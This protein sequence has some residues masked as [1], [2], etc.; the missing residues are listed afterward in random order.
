MLVNQIRSQSC[1]VWWQPQ[2]MMF[3]GSESCLNQTL[4][5]RSTTRNT[6]AH[7]H[8]YKHLHICIHTNTHAH[9]HENTHTHMRAL[10]YTCTHKQTHTEKCPYHKL[11]NNLSCSDIIRRKEK[12]HRTREII[13]FKASTILDQESLY[14][15]LLWIWA[16]LTCWY[17]VFHFDM[18][19]KV[20]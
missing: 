3:L 10:T 16:Q 9:T 13:I 14:S 17:N 2:A 8:A 6:N 12:V 15:I 18:T 11:C 1:W 5:F 20:D 4:A 19:Y 7:T